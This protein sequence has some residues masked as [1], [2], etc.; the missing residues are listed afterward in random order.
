[1]SRHCAGHCYV[2]SSSRTRTW[3]PLLQVYM[4]T[5]DY[6][7]DCTARVYSS[8]ALWYPEVAE[9]QYR[10]P[11]Q[12]YRALFHRL[13]RHW[14]L[15]TDVP[16]V[17]LP[18]G[19]VYAIP[20]GKSIG[21]NGEQNC[22]IACWRDTCASVC[23]LFPYGDRERK[24]W[25]KGGRSTVFSTGFAC[26]PKPGLEAVPQTCAQVPRILKFNVEYT[27]FWNRIFS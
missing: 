15:V 10:S 24:V 11:M 8:S 3:P 6:R 1:M 14:P 12:K 23:M 21:K 13:G 20:Y 17:K 7:V 22:D 19:S 16:I 27:L 18:P 2:Q 4:C 9:S 26:R 25:V 5:L